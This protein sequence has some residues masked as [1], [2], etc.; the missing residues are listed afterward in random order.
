MNVVT[1]L[2]SVTGGPVPAAVLAD[3]MILDTTVPASR[4][5]IVNLVV[6][7]VLLIATLPFTEYVII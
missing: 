3:T 2:L 5:N 6:V 7:D 1:V 4:L